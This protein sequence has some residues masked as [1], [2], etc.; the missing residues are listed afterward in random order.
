MLL[1]SK[2]KEQAEKERQRQEN[3][4]RRDDDN[5][6]KMRYN[7]QHNIRLCLFH[8][9]NICF[10]NMSS[11]P[12]TSDL[13]M[14]SSS[15][16]LHVS[17]TAGTRV[18]LPTPSPPAIIHQRSQAVAST[19]LA[20]MTAAP[21]VPTQTSAPLMSTSPAQDKAAAERERQRQ[22]EQERRRR[23]AVS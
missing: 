14:S 9:A 4:R 6:D 2:K 8:I 7:I 23:E 19:T 11:T 10:R 22:R 5:P 13:M 21:V 16:R 15:D 12:L 18:S 20:A 3:E 1:E 17:G